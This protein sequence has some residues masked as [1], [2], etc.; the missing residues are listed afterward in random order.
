MTSTDRVVS[1][2]IVNF[3]SG[4]LITQCVKS[5]LTSTIPFEIFIVDNASID[6]SIERLKSTIDITQHPIYLIENKENI[7]FAA[8]SN[9]VI[10]QTQGDYLLFLNPDCVLQPNT[11]TQ[12][13]TT[14]DQH[15]HIGMAGG[16]VCNVDGTEQ[17]GCRRSV[18]S[19]WRAL[20][21]VFHLNKLFPNH[22]RFKS[23]VLTQEPLPKEPI[24][25]EG[26]SGACMFVR[27]KAL[28][29]VGPMDESYFLH[30]EDLDWFMRFRA[31]HW[32]ILFIPQIKITHVKGACSHS[33][34]I[35]VLWY[36]HRGM[37]KFYR[38]FFLHQ[39]PIW[40]L[41]G[42]I[43]AVWTRFFLLAI[44]TLWSRWWQLDAHK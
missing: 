14:L 11:L 4:D 35:K 1:V 34:P 42:V 15:S 12:F 9:Q 7:G 23:F 27:R 21:R 13:Q 41:W 38:K 28:L 40:V 26:I 25:I 3:N 39:Y 10:E 43:T 44:K 33:Q 30:C 36:K 29:E 19:P 31:H 32:P 18:P 2:I 20:I 17:A 6:H 37:V 8:A 16:L 5:L 22:P 24:E